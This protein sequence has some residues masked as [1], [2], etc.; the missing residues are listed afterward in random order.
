MTTQTHTVQY[1][2]YNCQVIKRHYPKGGNI[3]LQLMSSSGPVATATVNLIDYYSPLPEGLCWIKIYE[4][5]GMLE[6]LEQ[7]GIVRSTG[8]TVSAGYV[9]QYAVIC[10][11]LI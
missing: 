1:F 9:S 10:E 6:T 7:A 3:A 5:P 8:Q 11:C 4:Q 2:G